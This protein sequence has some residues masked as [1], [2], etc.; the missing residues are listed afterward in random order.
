MICEICNKESEETKE[1]KQKNQ[2][3]WLDVCPDC[4]ESLKFDGSIE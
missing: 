2:N 4:Y 3:L 1:V